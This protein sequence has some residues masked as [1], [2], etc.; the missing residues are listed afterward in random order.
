MGALIGNVA[1]IVLVKVLAWS[2]PSPAHPL[3]THAKV[4]VRYV[5]YGASHLRSPTLLAGK[6]PSKLGSQ[7]N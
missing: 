5:F 6:S 4:E 1:S 7:G 2:V 3:P